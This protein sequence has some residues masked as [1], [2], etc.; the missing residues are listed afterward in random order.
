MRSGSMVA[1]PEGRLLLAEASR[2]FSRISGEL[3]TMV[4]APP[5][6]IAAEIGSSRRCIVSPVRAASR[7][8]TGRYNAITDGFC[9]KEEFRP[10][11]AVVIISSRCS[12][13]WPRRSSQ[14]AS[15]FS[16]P[17]RSRPAPR[18]VVAMMLITALPEKPPKI[19]SGAISPVTPS[20]TSTTSAT[21]SAR[22]RSNRNIAIVKPTSPSTSFMSLVSVSAVS[23]WGAASSGDRQVRSYNRSQTPWPSFWPRVSKCVCGRQSGRGTL[24][25]G[26]A[27]LT[28]PAVAS[29]TSHICSA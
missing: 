7:E 9:M 24:P 1:R 15:R 14:A 28:S 2:S 20:T 27:R 13:P 3:P 26:P 18:M 5:I 4:S 10:A 16:A 11:M 22:M 6:T 21:T 12:T 8:A 19:S 25:R 17:V 23:M 29:S